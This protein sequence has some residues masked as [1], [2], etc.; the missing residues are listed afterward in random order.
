MAFFESAPKIELEVVMRLNESEARFLE[1]LSGFDHDKLLEAIRRHVGTHY[2]E[3]KAP[4]PGG[5]HSLMN[6]CQRDLPA[7]LDRIRQARAVFNG[8]LQ[9]VHEQPRT[10]SAEKQKEKNP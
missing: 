10:G 1:G 7:I 2:T 4:H 6:G 3:G 5:F 8:E 9:T